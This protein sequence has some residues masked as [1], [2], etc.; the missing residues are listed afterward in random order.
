MVKTLVFRQVIQRSAAAKPKVRG[1]KDDLFNAR[2]DNSARAHY[3]RLHCDIQNASVQIPRFEFFVGAAYR[4]DFGMT[5]GVIVFF[6]L[7]A[8]F[9]YNFSVL[10]YYGAYGHILSL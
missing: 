9:G 7:V 2:V 1:A 3:A 8:A 6:T 4:H 5:G 10:Y